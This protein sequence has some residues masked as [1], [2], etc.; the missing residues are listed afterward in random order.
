L[1]VVAV[2]RPPLA[3]RLEKK[4]DNLHLV[5]R[6]EQTQPASKSFRA[7]SPPRLPVMGPSQAAEAIVRTA[8][9]GHNPEF[10]GLEHRLS[11][12]TPMLIVPLRAP[13]AW[14]DGV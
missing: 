2:F 10:A 6:G 7:V 9:Y 1:F 3:Y 11:A 13:P 8:L 5:S 14:E 12:E 4:I